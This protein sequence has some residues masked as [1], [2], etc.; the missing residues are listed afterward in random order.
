MVWG[1]DGNEGIDVGLMSG[2]VGIVMSEFMR[3][4]GVLGSKLE[5]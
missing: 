5:N 3:G 4:W 1:W 2:W